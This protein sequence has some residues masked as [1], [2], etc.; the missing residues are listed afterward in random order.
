MTLLVDLVNI[1]VG[2]TVNAL[3]EGSQYFPKL[4]QNQLDTF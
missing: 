1:K 4:T 3:I 2:T